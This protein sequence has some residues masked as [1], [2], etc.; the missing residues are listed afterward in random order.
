MI[1]A[2]VRYLKGVGPARAELLKKCGIET[3]GDLILHLPRKFLDRRTVIPVA[4][5]RAGMIV[6]VVGK[7]LT[8]NSAKSRRGR[9]MLHVVL[10]DGSGSIVMTFFNP[11]YLIKKLKPGISVSATGK[12]EIFKRLSLLHPELGFLDESSYSRFFEKGILPVY[13]LTSGLAQGW[14]RN[15]ITKTLDDVEP[16]IKEILPVNVLQKAG[17]EK[18]SEL[19]YAI[20][21]PGSPEEAYRARDLLALEELFLYQVLLRHFRDKTK[22]EQGI[23]FSHSSETVLNFLKTLPF[24]LTSAQVRVLE[25]IRNDMVSSQPMRRLLHGDVGSGK[26][27]VAA[28]ACWICH[29][30]GYQSAVLA[31]TEV[32][33]QQ[34]FR[35]FSGFLKP[36]NIE[37]RILTGGSKA[38]E[39][40]EILGLLEDGYLNVIV[41]THALIQEGVK[42]RK[43][44]FVVVDEQHRFG[45]IQRERILENIKP[46]PDMLV[47]SATPIPRTLS[48]TM[49]GDLDISVIDEMPP[50][51]GKT[52]TRLV[53]SGGKKALLKFIEDRIK[54]G[55]RAYIIYPLKETSENLD[56]KDA[57]GAFEILKKGFL[58][59]YG[60]EL[61]HGSMTSAEKYN[62]SR[63][64]AEGSFSTLVSTTV[65]EVG[66]DVPEATIMVIVNAERFGLSQLHQLRGRIGRGSRNS[67][68]FLIPGSRTGSDK[69]AER[70]KIML[71][72]NDGF[73]IA[74]KDLE[75]RGPGELFGT[76]QHG[77]PVFRIADLIED[78]DL[79]IKAANL[80]KKCVLNENIR[81]EL[82]LRFGNLLKPKV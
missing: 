73:K 79:I 63:G 31:P 11:G 13:P 6:T 42:F 32:L 76:K 7:I 30:C 37:S 22:R 70:L 9:R 38:G 17:F 64:F 44:G 74:K 43:L 54:K 27:A 28:A 48:M 47:M 81:S 40:K 4:N 36:L 69:S 55:E 71:E 29:C 35:T 49:Y 5:V 46:R 56:L 59:Q 53:T 12:A 45:V 18:R 21:L 14:M 8:V 10:D 67:W 50:G 39:K 77:L 60:I 25:E 66:V 57:T 72:T 23:P 16:E 52:E 62:I 26:T 20:H 58:G 80:S 65:V 24:E 78:Y 19:F 82:E 1:S 68:C 2:D 34:H 75:L 41:G 61:L 15:L 3:V 51:R 33:A